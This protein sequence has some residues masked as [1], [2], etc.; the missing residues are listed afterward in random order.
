ML[1][2][3]RNKICLVMVISDKDMGSH[4]DSKDKKKHFN[5]GFV[6]TGNISILHLNI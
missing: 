5:N 6:Y 4:I 1:I 3:I 2:Q